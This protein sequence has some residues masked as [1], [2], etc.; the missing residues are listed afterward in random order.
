MF[1]SCYAP[2]NDERIFPAIPVCARVAD[3]SVLQRGR[4]VQVPIIE[5][6]RIELR[7]LDR[8]NIAIVLAW[9]G[10]SEVNR[11][12]LSG[13]EPIPY[14]EEVRWY[15]AMLASETDLVLQIHDR[16]S[17]KYLGNTGLHRIDRTHRGAEL[18]IMIGDTSEWGRGYGRE[19]MVTLLRF[20]FGTLGLHRVML[21]CHPDNERGLAAYRAIG[22]TEIGH[23]REAVFIDGQWQDHL[24]FDMLEHE[25]RALHGATG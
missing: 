21:R 13:H 5:G 9:L 14:E 4:S 20:A 24:V 7:P 23:E 10:D 2:E 16:V 1:R 22:F 8:E 12:M 18:G 19:A 3:N 17:G 11:Y 15:E 25:F 6:D